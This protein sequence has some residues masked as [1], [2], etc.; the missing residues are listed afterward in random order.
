MTGNEVDVLFDDM[1]TFEDWGLRLEKI[2]LSF[3]D[4]KLDLV[5]IPGADGVSDLTEANG[6]VR[7]ENRDIQLVFSLVGGYAGWHTLVSLIAAKLHGKLRKCILPDD[8]AFFYQGRFTLETEKDSP[9]VT[10]IVISGNV[11]PY[12]QEAQDSLE[13]WLWN[14]FNFETGIIREYADIAVDGVLEVNIIG[15]E[16][17]VVPRIIV[18]NEMTVEF[19]NVV[20]E[21]VPGTNVI[22]DIVTSPGDNILKFEGHGAVSV[23]YRGGML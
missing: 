19:D 12:K 6:P 3:P 4:P 18:D 20:Y 16:M 9:A 7:Y 1:R 14:P 17:P 22:Y 15:R 21:L 2:T 23:G 11:E 8:P 5:D 10:G 13:D